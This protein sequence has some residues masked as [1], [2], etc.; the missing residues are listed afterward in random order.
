VLGEHEAALARYQQA[1]V[2]HREIDNRDGECFTWDNLGNIYHRLGRHSQAVA[3]YRHSIRLFR[4]LGNLPELA[5]TLT[6]LGDSLHVAGHP[7]D[8]H[9]A[10]QEAHT[11]LDSLHDPSASQI[12]ARLSRLRAA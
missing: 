4:E 10:W 3:C 6:R 11:I 5:A 9:T 8:A 12:L 2:L 7:R 1:L